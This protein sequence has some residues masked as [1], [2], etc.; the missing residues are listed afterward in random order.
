MFTKRFLFQLLGSFRYVLQMC[1]IGCKGDDNFHLITIFLST[2][3][4]FFAQGNLLYDSVCVTWASLFWRAEKAAVSSVR[5]RYNSSHMIQH[6]P[7]H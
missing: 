7:L 6:N 3:S 5:P 4:L 2:C 1:E